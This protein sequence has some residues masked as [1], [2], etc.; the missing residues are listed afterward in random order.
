MEYIASDVTRSKIL[1]VKARLMR[2]T[3]LVE[4]GYINE[5]FM[6]YQMIL[7]RKDLPDYGA[8]YSEFS[9]KQDGKNFKIPSDSAYNNHLPP[10]ADENQAAIKMI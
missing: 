10:E 9:L 4:L 6:I 2:A 3:A 7:N 8:K 5:A 1:T